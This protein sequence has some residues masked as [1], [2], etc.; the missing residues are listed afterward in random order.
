M[1]GINGILGNLRSEE[2]IGRM[3]TALAH[4]GPDDEGVYISEKIALGHRRLS[5]IDLSSAGHQPMATPDG[6]YRVIYNGE[7]YNF[8]ELKFELQR[9]PA[10]TKG[11]A[12]LFS[13]S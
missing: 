2:M 13:T 3:N 4:R 5:I 12:Y 6:R 10:D 7:L 11:G 8:K 1:C 9:A